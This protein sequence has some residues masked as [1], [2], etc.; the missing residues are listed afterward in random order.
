MPLNVYYLDDETDLCELFK[1]L[2]ETPE[3]Q[4]SIFTRPADFVA[5]VHAAAPDLAFVDYRLPGTTGEIICAGLPQTFP[6]ILVT[7]EVQL[8]SNANFFKVLRKPTQIDEVSAVLNSFL[9]AKV[10]V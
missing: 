4:I 8:S 1:E 10:A 6:K 3:I 5:A 9:A 2:Y 7:G